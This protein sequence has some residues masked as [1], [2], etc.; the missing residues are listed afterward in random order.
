MLQYIENEYFIVK[1]SSC[2]IDYVSVPVCVLNI[3]KY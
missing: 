3:N 1:T 2:A